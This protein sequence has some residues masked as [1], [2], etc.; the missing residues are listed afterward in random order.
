RRT[1]ETS[2]CKHESSCGGEDGA[3]PVGGDYPG[4]SGRLCRLGKSISGRAG[5][6][7]GGLQDRPGIMET[8]GAT[9]AQC[10]VPDDRA[11]NYGQEWA[12]SDGVSK[13]RAGT[14]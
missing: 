9:A 13:R 1:V 11:G 3:D 2:G 7:G 14:G 10:R 5:I 12:N 6:R 4:Q 8:A